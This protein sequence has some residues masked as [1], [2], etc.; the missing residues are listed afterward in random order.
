MT[1]TFI[2]TFI[3]GMAFGAIL[4]FVFAC[5]MDHLDRKNIPVRWDWR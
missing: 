4:L 2:L 5:W 3:G 1:W